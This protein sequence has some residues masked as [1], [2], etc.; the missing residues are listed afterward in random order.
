MGYPLQMTKRK[1]TTARIEAEKRYAPDRPKKP[2]S[3]RLDAVEMARLDNAAAGS[4]R[5]AYLRSTV[6]RAIEAHEQR[7]QTEA[8]YRERVANKINRRLGDDDPD[9]PT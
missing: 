6:L 9:P 4:S 8:A 1:R 7:L 3:I 2:V 5:S